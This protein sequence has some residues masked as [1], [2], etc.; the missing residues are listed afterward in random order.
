VIL[1]CSGFFADNV[2]WTGTP[3]SAIL[4]AARPRAD[5]KSLRITSGS[6]GYWVNL[7]REDYDFEQVILAYQVNGED[8]PLE[9]GYPVRLVIKD[10]Y[11][12]K[13]VK[14]VEHI[15]VLEK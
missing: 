11:G 9:H 6:D 14:W 8:I 10:E 12:A 4:E 3:V 7:E 13:W 1:I 5:F 15:E 2:E